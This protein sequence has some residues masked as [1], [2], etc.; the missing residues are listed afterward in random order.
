MKYTLQRNVSAHESEVQ[1]ARM[2]FSTDFYET[3]D[4]YKWAGLLPFTYGGSVEEVAAR[5]EIEPTSEYRGPT[6]AP[7]SKKYQF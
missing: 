7:P 5:D 6:F 4:Y 1:L 2:L 3:E